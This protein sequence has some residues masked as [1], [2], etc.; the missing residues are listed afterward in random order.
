MAYPVEESQFVPVNGTFD[1]PFRPAAAGLVTVILVASGSLP[2]R[3]GNGGGNNGSGSGTT[4]T[5]SPALG[6]AAPD[7]SVPSPFTVAVQLDVVKPGAT[8]PAAEPVS[9]VANVYGPDVS[10]Q[11]VLHLDVMATE[12][13]LGSDWRARVT[14]PPQGLIPHYPLA[15]TQCDLTVRYQVQPGNLGKIDHIVVAM[16][17]NRSFDHML[18]YLSLKPPYGPGRTD[19]DGLTGAEYNL[20]SAAPPNKCT[21]KPRV[22]PNPQASDTMF[23][24]DPGHGWSDVQQQLGADSRDP[25]LTS[26]AGFV[27]NFAQQIAIDV[28]NLPPGGGSVDLTAQIPALGTHGV[29]F[30]PGLPGTI[31][32]VATPANPPNHSSSGLLG[33]IALRMPGASGD[34]VSVPTPIGQTRLGLSYDATQAQLNPPGNWVCIISNGTDQSLSFTINLSYVAEAHDTSDAEQPDAVMSYY[35]AAQ[36]PVYDFLARNFA[37]CDRWYASIPTDTWP[38][39]LYALTGG[40]DGLLETPSDYAVEQGPPGYLLTAIFE[41]LQGAQ[42]DW[43]VFFSDLPFALIFTRLAQ[44]VT[45]TARMRT[46]DDLAARAATGKLPSF[47]WVD[48]NFQDVPDDPD[49]ASDDHPPG[50]VSHGQAFISRVYNALASGP[51][52]GKTLLIITYDEHGGFYDHVLPPTDLYL[53]TKLEAAAAAPEPDAPAPIPAVPRLPGQ[54]AQTGRGDGPPDDNPFLHRYGLRVPAIVVSPWT[55]PQSCS[56]EVFDHTSILSTVLHRFCQDADGTVPSMSARANAA[57][58]VGDTLAASS[59]A[60]TPPSAPTVTPA[61]STPE[62]TVTSGT[63]ADVLRQSLFGF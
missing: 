52:W 30:R 10:N 26:N 5:S 32:V 7:A 43:N 21:V 47:C 44:D 19:V 38:N 9:A 25:A 49:N 58:H 27:V 59:P 56:H 1:V 34:L 63:F 46:I 50:D 31:S 18:G 23:L 51:A 20:D 61:G 13:D 41:I 15:P 40:S 12:S 48:P 28:Q 17:E 8:T 60:L 57:R 62:V 4:P 22:A 14:N 54:P 3:G 45:Y 24:T 29:V 53:Q 37:I 42:V 11:V 33:S 55:T 35:S 39:R 36:L 6:A 16:M 2:A